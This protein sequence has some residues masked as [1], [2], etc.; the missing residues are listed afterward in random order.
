MLRM[1]VN[2]VLRKIL[3]TKCE[4]VRADYRRLHIEQLYDLYPHKILLGDHMWGGR[5]A[6]HVACMGE[7]KNA[8]SVVIGN[9][10]K[11]TGKTKA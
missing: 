7:N 5:W 2:Q 1:L 11:T 3:R 4:K 9:P 10:E 6:Q 8:Y